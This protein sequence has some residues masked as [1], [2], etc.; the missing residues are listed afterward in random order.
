MLSE[1]DIKRIMGNKVQTERKIYAVMETCKNA[2]TDWAKNYWFN[3]WKQL[4][5]KYGRQDLYNQ[6][7]H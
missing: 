3:V 2:K 6:N 5:I 7:L 1:V 4:C